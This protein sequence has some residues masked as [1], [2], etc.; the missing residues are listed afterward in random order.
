MDGE[1]RNHRET[2]DMKGK[3]QSDVDLQHRLQGRGICLSKHRVSIE[4]VGSPRE[5]NGP[6][7]LAQ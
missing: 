5:K 1:T 4:E 7:A 3:E 2:E 6:A